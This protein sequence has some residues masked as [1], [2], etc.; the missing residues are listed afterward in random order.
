MTAAPIAISAILSYLLGSLP[1]GY[2]MAKA[3][4]IDIRSVGS[5]NIGATNVFRA[6]GKPAGIITLVV[7]CAKGFIAVF[8]VPGPIARATGVPAHET[9]PIICALAVILGH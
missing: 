2:L 3:K 5:G 6:L 9:L 1:T 4:G 7:D 8:F